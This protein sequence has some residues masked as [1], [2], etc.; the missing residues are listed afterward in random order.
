MLLTLPKEILSY[1]LSLVVVEKY[2]SYYMSIHS[3]SQ[4]NFKEAIAI[5]KLM[6]VGPSEGVGCFVR[7]Y[8]ES[9]MSKTMKNLSSIHPTIRQLLRRVTIVHSETLW[10]FDQRFFSTC[11]NGG[12]E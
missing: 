4:T 3:K 5:R 7:S 1:I 8:G 2:M 6:R 12:A 11:T 10:R 9:P